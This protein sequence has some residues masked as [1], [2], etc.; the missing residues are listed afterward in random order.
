PDQALAAELRRPAAGR[1]EPGRHRSAGAALLGVAHPPRPEGRAGRAGRRPRQ[2][3]AG[4]RDAPRWAQPCGGARARD[5]DRGPAAL[6][7]PP[8]RPGGREAVSLRPGPMQLAGKRI[9]VTGAA[10][11]IGAATVRA[12]AGE[13]AR[14]AALD[15]ADER[16]HEVAAEAGPQVAYHH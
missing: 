4:A 2:L 8:R 6:R 16:G 15:V 1:R 12:Y 10:N 11:G 14:V 7:R 3:A 9:I 5:P 13:G